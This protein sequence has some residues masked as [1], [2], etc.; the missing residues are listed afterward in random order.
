[1][2]QR[3]GRP[4][5]EG[6][7]NGDQWKSALRKFLVERFQ[8]K[9]HSED[10]EMPV[11]LLEQAKGGSKLFKSEAPADGPKGL[12][13]QGAGIFVARNATMLDFCGLLQ[14][15]LLDRPVLDK[16]D[17]GDNRY[18]FKLTWQPDATQFGGRFANAP[19]FD[20]PRPDLYTALQEQI[21]LKATPTKAPAKVMVFE[22]FEKPSEN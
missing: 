18:D 8:L 22:K 17:L 12:N 2:G 7:P 1:M 19:V 21:G 16:T 5:G 14:E 9:F 10:R 13:F 3:D 20:Q 15:T 4:D 11:Y 6:Q